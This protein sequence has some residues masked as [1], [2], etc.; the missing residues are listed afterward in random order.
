MSNKF[1]TLLTTGKQALI[2]AITNSA[3]IADANKIVSTGTDGKL[4]ISLFPAGVDVQAENAIASEAL[5]SGNW[6]N[7]FDDAGV[8][9][10]RKADAANNRPANGF[11]LEGIASGESGIFYAAGINAQ[12]SGLAPGATYF[13]SA[14]TPG[15]L[16]NTMPSLT[17]GNF[18]QFL[19]YA[20]SATSLRFEYDEPIYIV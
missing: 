13:L 18:V 17:S 19:G 11:V 1:I 2:S 20:S 12:L 14:D 9:K 7:I 15:T 6:I 4:N 16:T 10:I 3:G 5:A 8:R